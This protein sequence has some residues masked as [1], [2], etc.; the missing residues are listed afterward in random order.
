MTNNIHTVAHKHI[1]PTCV[2]YHSLS[3]GRTQANNV[4]YAMSDSMPVPKTQNVTRT[5]S[6]V[7]TT[8]ALNP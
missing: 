8:A 7:D 5:E 3:G 2:L 6:C 4:M 1:A